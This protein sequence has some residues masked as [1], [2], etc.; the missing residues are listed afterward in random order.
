M[1]KYM[2]HFVLVLNVI[3]GDGFENHIRFL[4]ADLATLPQAKHDQNWSAK[5]HSRQNNEV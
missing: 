5:V 3:L 1:V 2:L 4:V